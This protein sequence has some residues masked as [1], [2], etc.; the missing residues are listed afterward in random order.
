MRISVIGC[1]YLG[2][3]H[4]ACLAA[5]GHEVVG[6]DVEEAKIQT[7]RSGKAPFYEPGLNELLQK[8]NERL[9]WSTELA[10][11]ASCSI[12]FLAVGT[13]QG[14]QGLDLS[15][16]ESVVRG[17]AGVLQGEDHLIVGKSTVPPG[18]AAHLESLCDIEVAWNPEFLRETR[19]V[20]DTLRPS[21]IVIGART[22]RADQ[23]LRELWA[24]PIGRGCPVVSCDRETAEMVKLASNAFL[25]TKL[26]FINAIGNVCVEVGADTS[27]LAKAMG[28]D[29]RI[30]QK[31]MHAGLGF[32]GG[33][34]PKDIRGLGHIAEEVGATSAVGLLRHVDAVNARQRQRA[35][36]GLGDVR[37]KRVAVLGT[38]FKAGTDD[39]RDSPAIDVASQIKA[40]GGTPC[41]YDPMAPC[42]VDKLEAALRGA[43]GVVIATEWR[44]FAMIDPA[45]ARGLVV[46]PLVVD[47]RGVLD[48]GAWQAAGWKVV[49]LA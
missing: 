41:S 21:R 38:A 32:G 17:L 1:G 31:F 33:C 16:L 10:D 48:K 13:P 43:H 44:E 40:A 11:A 22:A 47:A 25:A 39:T 2:A 18:T 15:A 12:H 49:R 9:R 24:V 20:E 4:A 7:L 5:L 36:E 23:L 29:P 26:S 19:G 37:G 35:I 8:N 34:L 27:T 45:W 46:E 3:T 30:G 42:D 28:L 6:I 14:Q